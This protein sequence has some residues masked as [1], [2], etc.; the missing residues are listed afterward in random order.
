MSDPRYPLGRFQPDPNPTFESRAHHIEQIAGLPRLFRQAVS[1]LDRNQLNT[2]YRDG[3]WSVLQL[4]HHVP[5]SHM[6]AYIR[7][8]LALTEDTPT[9]GLYKE[10]AWARLKDSELTPLEVSLAI[11]ENVHARWTVLLK[12]M[13]AEEF[14][15]K[16]RHPEYGVHTLDRLLATYSWHGNHHVAHITSLRERMKW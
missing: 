13:Q 12:S 9:I 5:D 10:D 11:L 6:Q 3:G 7:F 8:K 4:A 16:Y 2:P 15:R 1:G 14:H